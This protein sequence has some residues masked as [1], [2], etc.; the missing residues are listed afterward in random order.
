M[1]AVYK[2]FYSLARKSFSKETNLSE[3]Y[4]RASYQEVL[5]ALDYVKRTRG[6]GLLMGEPRVGKTFALRHFKES[7]NPSLYHVV[8]FPLSTGSVMDFYHGLPF[9]LEEEP[10]YCKVDLF[11]QIHQGIESLYRER[12]VTPMFI[13]DENAFS[14]ERFSKEYRDLVQLSYGLDESVSL[15]FGGAAPFTGR[16]SVKSTPSASPTDHHHAIPDGTSQQGRGGWI[17]RA[18]LETG[19]SKTSDFHLGRLGSDRTAVAMVAADHQYPG[20]Q[21]SVIN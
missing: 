17:Y 21:L 19:G 1:K 16:T 18:S 14:E 13:L 4:Q 12:R 3:A 5:V 9:G 6:I 8:C 7:L 10:K 11:H 2:T 20:H 15:D